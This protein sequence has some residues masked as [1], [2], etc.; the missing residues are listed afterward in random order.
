M[1]SGQ[2]ARGSAPAKYDIV[3]S[4][5]LITP[6]VKWAHPYANGPIRAFSASR[7]SRAS[8]ALTRTGM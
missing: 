6:H 1:A 7:W 8:S 2:S 4:P 5:E 3:Y